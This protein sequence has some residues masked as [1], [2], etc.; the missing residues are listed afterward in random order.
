ME[1]HEDK[2]DNILFDE[3]AYTRLEQGLD[4]VY[5]AIKG[6]LGPKG[7]NVAIEK[8]VQDPQI[9]N[10][11]AYIVRELEFEG[12]DRHA[13]A[14]I[15]K[16]ASIKTS[17]SSGDGTTSSVILA[18]TLYQKARKAIASGV[19]PTYI[20]RGMDKALEHAIS[21]VQDFSFPVD[22]PDEIKHVASMSAG[23][24]NALGDMIAEAIEM[25]GKDGIIRVEEGDSVQTSLEFSEGMQIDRGYISTDFVSDGETEISFDDCLVYVADDRLTDMD[26]VL[27]PMEYA[28]QHDRPL[29]VIA[30]D[31]EDQ[32]LAAL[33]QNQDQGNLDCCA[34]KAPRVAEKRATILDCIAILTNGSVMS[35]QKGMSPTSSDPDRYLG[36]A[37]QVTV[38][39]NKSTILG[40][41]GD[42][43]DV[44]TKIRSLRTK[45][46]EAGSEHD[47]EFYQK[48]VSQMSGGM[49][50]IKVGGQTELELKEYK[51]DVEDALS[52]TRAAVKQ[53]FVPGGGVTFL[54][55]QEY[56][57]DL[58]DH[59][60]V[61]F[62]NFEEEYG[63]KI[64]TES[65]S[66]IFEHVL[67][68]SDFNADV[69]L[70]QYRQQKEGGDIEVGD[71]FD[72]RTGTF[73]NGYDVGVIEP[74]MVAKDVLSHATSVASS[75]ITTSCLIEGSDDE[76]EG[77]LPS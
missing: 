13:G 5:H 62:E 58:R 36:I 42:K 4:E 51:A 44:K 66:T 30:H 41:E 48:M 55:T 56:L 23:G 59:N 38:D 40:G 17:E 1:D 21:F 68:N 69:Y 72:V 71:V 61:E 63:W 75:L 43:E 33:V 20:K 77:D 18:H 24:D 45:L 27:R 9:T 46:D 26:D 22:D 53:G 16:E 67:N 8:M 3:D 34:V 49:A 50:I 39:Q 47:K 65:L 57:N 31:I 7:R 12:D 64:L 76:D 25:V 35:Q 15:I 14:E 54:E 28:S 2:R 32:A 60:D 37:D 11:G 19:H 74:T 10:D 70:F 29:F 73:E 6:T 52:A